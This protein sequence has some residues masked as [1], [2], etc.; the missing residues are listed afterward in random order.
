[1][2]RPSIL[3]AVFDLDDTLYPER[4]Y[5]R[6]GYA[7]VADCLRRR[8]GREERFDEWLWRR[9]CA[10]RSEAALD[11]LSDA[12]GLGLSADAVGEL[13]NV[14]R[15]H[16][17]RITALPG[18]PELL[19]RLRG[20]GA[21]LGLLSD[22]FL[23]A[24]KLKLEALGLAGQFAAIVWTEELGR[25]FW[26]PSPAAFHRIARLLDAPHEA[27]AYVADNPAKDFVAGNALGWRTIQLRFEGQVHAG[28]PPAPGGQ[29]QTVARSLTELESL[30][31]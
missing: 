10:G 21:R 17:P 30:L 11:A 27:C 4:D 25:E 8:L 26:K 5:V 13:V 1:M 15:A 6:G 14:Y 3:A 16:R 28:K 22:G 20:R 31:A 29:P 12:F 24:Q 7:A 2:L 23:P 9:F 19:A 18:M